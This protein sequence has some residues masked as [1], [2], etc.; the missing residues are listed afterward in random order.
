MGLTDLSIRKMAPKIERYEVIDGK[1][2]AV[3]VMPSGTKSWIFRYMIDGKPRR[4]TL[5]GYP[6]VTL[7]KARELHATAM[8]DIQRGIDPGA[9]AQAAKAKLKA[10]PTVSDLLEEFFEQELKDA[11]SGKERRRL[12]EK[13]VIP[14]WGGRKVSDITRRDAVLLIDKVRKRAPIG[15][16]RLQS[17]M[18]RLWNFACE[19]GVIDF[20]PMVGLRRPKEATRSRVLTDEEIRLLWAGLDLNNTEIDIYKPTK[21]AIRMILLTGQRPGEASAM[22]WSE[23]DG[24]VWTI[25]PERAK[26][27]IENRVPLGPMVLETLEQARLFAGDGF[28]FPSSHKPGSP[29]SR[30]AMGKAINRH[31]A[32]MGIETAFTPHDLRRTVRTR[33]AAL[34]VSDVVAERVLGHKL[35]GMMAV[36]NRHAYDVEKRQSLMRWEAHLAEIVGESK[37]HSKVIPFKKKA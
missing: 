4:M 16:S 35:Q 18:V 11:P 3:R 25:P 20:S 2:L 8:Q 10:A 23:I 34:G 15:A 17:V 13:D 29:L 36:Y 31:W 26:N 33:L 6:G 28:V 5:G 32:E 21:L 37:T 30:A 1:G 7:A 12:V 27:R 24:A 9:K 14:A 19:R 22:S